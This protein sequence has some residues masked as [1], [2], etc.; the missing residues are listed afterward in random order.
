MAAAGLSLTY[1]ELRRAIGRAVGSGRSSSDWGAATAE[2]TDVNDALKQG[3]LQAYHPPST[4]GEAPHMWS[5]LR[6][7][8][9]ELEVHAPYTTGTVAIAADGGGSIVT[10]TDGTWPSWAAAG[11]VYV[12]GGWYTVASRT[13]DSTIVLDDTSVTVSSGASYSLVHRAYDM[14]DD[15]GGFVNRFTMRRDQTWREDIRQVHEGRIRQYDDDSW[16]TG[17]PTEFALVSVAPTSSQES[18]WQ[19]VFSPTPDQTYTLW[20]RYEVN[21]PLLEGSSY[22]YAHGYPWFHEVVLASC[23]DRAYRVF[24]NSEEKFPQFMTSLR[25]AVQ[26]DRTMTYGRSLGQG[27]RSD[28]IDNFRDRLTAH[29]SNATVTVSVT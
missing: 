28:D 6:P 3:L 17:P 22:N 10:L 11:E 8:V 19:A 21:P 9:T 16:S 14:P 1:T 23:I 24:L 5:F 2:N 20:Y 12:S 15:F 18:K 7:A 13:N 26:R 29:R 27:A 4:D 25:A